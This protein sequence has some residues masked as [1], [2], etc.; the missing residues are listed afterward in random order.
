M[1]QN[2]TDFLALWNIAKLMLPVKQVES[3]V[4]TLRP[5]LIIALILQL[6]FFWPSLWPFLIN[7]FLFVKQF[8]MLACVRFTVSLTLTPFTP[9]PPLPLVL[10]MS[11]NAPC[12]WLAGIALCGSVSATLFPIYRART[13]YK[14]QIFFSHRSHTMEICTLHKKCVG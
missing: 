3:L 7:L 11:T 6:L 10:W 8:S 5:C 9:P 14:H 4:T 2:I 13:V 12:C 1:G